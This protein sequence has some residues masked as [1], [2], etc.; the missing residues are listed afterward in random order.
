MLSTKPSFYGAGTEKRAVAERHRR[1]G[2]GPWPGSVLAAALSLL[3]VA[4]FVAPSP[5]NA[6]CADDIGVYVQAGQPAGKQVRTPL[7]IIHLTDLH[8]ALLAEDTDGATRRPVGGAA[9]VASYIKAE[10]LRALAEAGAEVLLVAS[11]DMMQGSAVSNLSGGAAV[12]SVMNELGFEACAIGNHEFDWGT[13]VLAERVKQAEFPFLSANIFLG[14][15]AE[16]PAWAPPST[17]VR[18]GRLKIGIIGA[19]TEETP[20]VAN[21]RMLVG[22]RFDKPAPVVNRVA[23]DLRKEGADVVVVLSHLGGAQD[24]DGSLTGPVAEFAAQLKGVDA[25][26]DGHSHTVAAG[27]VNSIPVMISGSHG[28]RLGVMKLEVVCDALQGS[29]TGQRPRAGARCTTRLVEQDVKPTFGDSVEP[30]KATAA[31]VDSYSRKFAAEIDRV[32]AVASVPISTG[33]QESALG[34]LVADV[35][36]EAAGVDM[37][38]TNAGGIRAGLDAGPVTIGEIFRILPFDNTIVTMY[39]T[40]E[41]VRKLLE[42]GTSSR[43]V[44]QVSGLRFSCRQDDPAGERVKSIWLEDGTPLS[45][46]GRYLVATNDFMAAGGDR[47]TTFKEGDTIRNTQVLVRDSVISSMEKIQLAGGQVTPPSLGRVELLQ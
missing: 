30:D 3:L 40:G 10:K 11:G 15:G 5:G 27:V 32:V 21:P 17:V 28:R 42:E 44:V 24:E 22:L 25:V 36:R 47:F 7:T 38:F 19:T 26:L 9:V 4:V 1:P 14:D 45:P 46:S 8:G 2:R 31:V 12:I 29:G 33:R 13:G 35:M 37:A 6:A 16:R 41:Q 23:A 20:V 18:K 34:N 43:G 39:L